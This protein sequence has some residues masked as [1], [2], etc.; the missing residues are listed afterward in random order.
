MR[1][2]ITLALLLVAAVRLHA[3]DDVIRRHFDVADGGTLRLDA[4]FGNI[5]IVSGGTGVAVEVVRESHG[6]H[7]AEE[8]ANHKVTFEQHGN[9]VVI[10][11][12]SENDRGWFNFSNLQVQWNVRVPAHTNVELKTSGGNIDLADLGGTVDAHTSGG[13]IKTGRL[14]GVANLYTSG[15]TVD[16]A[17]GAASITARS[18]GGSIHVGETAGKVDVRTSGGSVTIE[19]VAGD[20][21]A[22]SSGGSIRVDEAM[23]SVDAETSGGSIEAKLSR[24]P[25]GDSRL[26]TSGGGV[27]V[28]I[29]D[30]VK[31]DLDARASGGG[32]SSNV[33]VTVLGTQDE[34]SLKG[35]I[36][37]GGPRLVLRSSGGGIRVRPL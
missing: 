34:D 30:G 21:Y 18:S 25:R 17:G 23:G 14:G 37:G 35:Q 20:V 10:D 15:G 11:T 26:V 28:A 33:P 5:K 19:R 27:V 24:Q 7:A 16:V 29:A 9:D 4:G 2:T 6:R 13:N 36:N 3:A 32:V 8:L 31:L 12:K 22:R 1:R